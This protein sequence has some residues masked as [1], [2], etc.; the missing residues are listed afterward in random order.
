[1]LPSPQPLLLVE[2]PSVWGVLKIHL[3][4]VPPPL[5]AAGS[6]A[7]ESSLPRITRSAGEKTTFHTKW[8]LFANLTH[9]LLHRIVMDVIRLNL[10]LLFWLTAFALPHT[11][12]AKPVFSPKIGK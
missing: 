5:N 6:I 1:C 8:D 9:R 11:A 10:T 3:R 7:L 4:S 2:V 12:R